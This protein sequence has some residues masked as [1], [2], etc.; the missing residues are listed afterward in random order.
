MTGHI[1]SF[2]DNTPS[3]INGKEFFIDSPKRMFRTF[4]SDPKD[5]KAYCEIDLSACFS[6]RIFCPAFEYKADLG[7]SWPFKRR[8]FLYRN[9]LMILEIE[10]PG[11][12]QK[13]KGLIH[14][15]TEDNNYELGI[16]SLF[17]FNISNDPPL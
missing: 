14:I 3:A 9:D 13:G 15:Y 7:L 17:Y 2:Y 10:V 16:Y 6:R 8:W 12:Y 4:I 1:P 11:W 5:N